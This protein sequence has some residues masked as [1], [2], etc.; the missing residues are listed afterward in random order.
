MPPINPNLTGMISQQEAARLKELDRRVS[1]QQQSLDKFS[2]K[3]H[4]TEKLAYEVRR[5][6]SKG[7]NELETHIGKRCEQLARA[8][9]EV[10]K[11]AVLSNNNTTQAQMSTPSIPPIYLTSGLD[12]Q[13]Q[14]FSQKPGSALYPYHV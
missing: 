4:A 7:L 1:E 10:N 5:D 6:M 14:T 12:R 13:S 11:M 9:Q 3:L 2:G 8:V